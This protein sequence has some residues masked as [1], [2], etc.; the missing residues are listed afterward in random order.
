MPITDL[1]SRRQKILQGELPE[2]FT[3]ESLPKKLR[4][5]IVHIIRDSIGELSDEYG[6]DYPSQIYSH[7]DKVLSKEYGVF[8]LKKNGYQKSV[9][10][11]VLDFVLEEKSIEKV[12]DVIELAFSIIDKY[13]RKTYLESRYHTVSQGPDDAIIELN[14]R[15]K[16]NGIG[17][18]Y[19]SGEIIRMDSTL[20]HE[21]ITSPTLILLHD[22]KGSTP[23]L[24]E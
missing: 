6:H 10:D 5:Q 20:V 13:V 12:L 23:N 3:Y 14:Q 1:Y 18:S 21:N 17:Y 16:E 8:S 2:I 15:F 7:I 19:S 4:V 11:I 9:R 24:M 22:K